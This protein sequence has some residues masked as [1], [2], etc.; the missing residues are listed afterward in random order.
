M[1][2]TPPDSVQVL[3]V[4]DE[5]IVAKDLQGMLRQIGYVVPETASTGEAAVQKAVAN[6]PDLILMDINLRGS[7]DGVEAAERIRGKLDVPIVYLTANS[8]EAT[9]QRAKTTDPFG[10]LLKPFEERSLHAAIEMALYKHRTE[11]GIRQR[12][13]WLSTTLKSI[14]DGVITTDADGRVTFVNAVAEK[15]T[16][17][18]HAEAMHRPYSEVFHI[19]DETNRTPGKDRVALALTE[20]SCDIV[21]QQALL[22]ARAAKSEVLIEHSIAPIR[23]D[24]GQT[25]GCVIVFCDISDRKL[26]EEQLRHSQK[27]EAIGKLAGGVAHDFNNAITAMIGYSELILD[28]VSP[29]DPIHED[30]KQILHAAE[31]SA[32]LTN[33]LLAFSR[34]QVLQPQ[35][36]NIAKELSESEG[37]LR[38]L[39]GESITLK[40]STQT[41]L[42]NIKA[43]PGYIHQVIL[44]MA[45]NA[46]DAM[47]NGGELSIEVCNVELTSA[48]AARLPDARSGEFV[49]LS[50][51]D[52]GC[53]ITPEVMQRIFEPF[54]TTKDPERGTGLGLATCYG[55]VK[56]NC[57]FIA[58]K[59]TP[60]TGTTFAVH[61][62]RL[63]DSDG[64]LGERMPRGESISGGNETVLVTEDDS[65]LRSLAVRV[66]EE[67]GY[68]VIEACDGMDAIELLQ[69]E[70]RIPID[71]LVTDLVMPRMNGRQLAVMAQEMFPD[72]LVLFMSGYTDDSIIREAIGSAEVNFLQKPFTSQALAMRVR[73]ILSE[74]GHHRNTPARITKNESVTVV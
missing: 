58:V 63:L 64:G 39:I 41:D 8:D 71:L 52:T 61:L 48:D 29:D 34:K 72:M 15:L 1:N 59:S 51:S 20:G 50:I 43:D 26:L 21:N 18:R 44:N 42:W 57:G 28:R 3:I 12:E 25:L 46:R 74:P 33:Q 5:G 66:L 73:E 30:A 65:I 31:R 60:S 54:F 16:G 49:R 23:E 56:Q 10:F 6:R 7:I 37:M 68:N 69:Q 19:L 55:I 2:R 24:E 17:W 36:M 9:L 27:M 35:V 70:R 4:E 45:V 67:H 47:L 38:R 40:T 22:I 14:A 62:P 11:R 32:Q 13:Q 53:G